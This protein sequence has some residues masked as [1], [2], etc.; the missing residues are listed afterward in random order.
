MTLI[1]K[2]RL[3]FYLLVFLVCLPIVF[4]DWDSQ[5]TCAVGGNC[6]IAI[7]TVN[8]S[9]PIQELNGS[10]SDCWVFVYNDDD[11]SRVLI[12]NASMNEPNASDNL[13]NYTISFND[14]GHYPSILTCNG[15]DVDDIKDFSFEVSD[16]AGGST[17]DIGWPIAL[18]LA[19]VGVISLLVYYSIQFGKA[20]QELSFFVQNFN[21][22]IRILFFFAA[23][24]ILIVGV[25]VSRLVV[26]ELSPASTDVV[27]LLDATHIGLIY[28]FLVVFMYLSAFYIID[29]IKNIKLRK[30]KDGRTRA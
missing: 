9:N 6:S 2:K 13:H 14:S 30:S 23:F 25:N 3:S 21:S 8:S 11:Y 16:S 24:L 18:L 5:V 10:Q 29:L 28:I 7:F 27:R 12:Y 17:Q 20:N 26:E 4:G 19:F 1:K 15:T 22:A